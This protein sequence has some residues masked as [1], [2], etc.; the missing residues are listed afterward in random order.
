MRKARA[1]ARAVPPAVAAEV[2]DLPA[3][4]STKFV[5]DRNPVRQ[6]LHLG[7]SGK[8]ATLKD[9]GYSVEFA[10]DVSVR[11][12]KSTA[13]LRKNE[14][15]LIPKPVSVLDHAPKAADLAVVRWVGPQVRSKPSEVLDSLAGQFVFAEDDLKT[16]RNGLR[17]PQLGAIHAVLGYW[18]TNVFQPAT[19]VMPTGTGKT[20]AML[21]LFAV[22]RPRRILVVVPSDTLRDQVAV[23][24]ET[25]GVLRQ[26]GVIGASALRPVVGRVEH[27]FKTTAAARQFASECNVIIATASALTASAPGPRQ[28]LIDECSHL[29][30]DEAH[31]VAASTWK[32]IRDLF[33]KK[34]VLQFT[35]TPFREDGKPL[36]GRLLYSFP[37]K[38][39]QKQGYF[40]KINYYSV[41][42]FQN[43]DR[44]IAAKAVE[45]L[46][47]DLN[48]KR[49]HI[50]MARVKNISRTT[51]V[52]GIYSELAPDLNPV[53]LHSGLTQ[54]VRRE[55]FEAVKSRKSRVIVCVDMLGEGFDLP[56]LKVAAMH[57]THR[58]L[59]VTLQFIGRFA[60]PGEGIGEAT[61]VVGRPDTDHDENLRKLYAEDPDWNDIIQNLSQQAIGQEEEVSEF[62]KAFHELSD[63]VSISNLLPKMSTVVYRTKTEDWKPENITGLFPE[64]SLLTFP[65][66]INP[67]DHV[68]WFV[69]KLH[70]PVT[71]GDVRT[72]QDV[73]H[74]LY[75]VYWDATRQLLYVNS[76]NTDSLHEALAKTICGDDVER[77]IGENVFR[78]MHNV[79]RLVPTNV[80]VLDIH[81]RSRRF[82]FHV[83]ADV[84]EG[85]PLA[86]AKTKTKTNLFAYGFEEGARVSLGASLKG[87]VWS[88]QTAPSLKH[89]MDWCNH[90]GGKLIDDKINLDELMRKF[91]RPKVLDGRPA[92]IPLA[93]EWPWHVFLNISDEVKIGSDSGA[94]PLIDCELEITEFST[95]GPI[96]FQVTTPMEQ[97]PY[98]A[99]L[100]EGRVTYRATERELDLVVKQNRTPLSQWLGQQGLWIRFEQDAAVTPDGFWLKVDADLPPF[101]REQ[102][103]NLDWS[104]VD[105]RKESQGP[106]RAADSI[107]AR[108][109]KHVRGL[110]N[111][112][113]LI[114]D[115]G[116]GEVADVVALRVDG[117][118]L[119]VL[120][121][122]CK[123]SSG[124]K[125]GSRVADLYEVC[126][127]A[128]KSVKWEQ[129]A[130]VLMKHLIRR[131]QLRVTSGLR[132]GIEVG[133]A[134][135]FFTI[136]EKARMLRPR[137]TFAI[138][139]PGLSKA[140]ATT[141]QLQLLASAEVYVRET[142]NS[143]LTVFCSS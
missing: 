47:S 121:V 98:E 59:G 31:H 103:K 29:F 22:A 37:L 4:H 141:D 92:F 140:G 55:A 136:R 90:I 61:F 84:V 71:W 105:L 36:G 112:D 23:K 77:I 85:F 108:V 123:Y 116:T 109:I 102:L 133:K 120:L 49:D 27:G 142:A 46:R 45:Q 78:I 100:G 86:E 33:A 106:K 52:V 20:E 42:D 128:I 131:E 89:W 80:G 66:P 93:L 60:R 19:I 115:D 26:V 101:D 87:R 28:V 143:P 57:D 62:E 8:I 58:S 67:T 18:T 130:S 53:V 16:G 38:E 110:A 94:W 127:Q 13:K 3:S 14:R 75:V 65:V 124:D 91:I 97:V 17:I 129:D 63:D 24:F 69:T 135:T 30:V 12:L 126:G 74:D 118:D 111:W 1:P 113:L 35:A 34:H 64:E 41:V 7:G 83:G 134:S 79:N 10:H 21:G 32:Q 132:S 51:D 139:Q 114:D 82:S 44:T 96:K 48:Q 122:H 2:V 88:F 72:V 11:L 5:V 117:K 25:F 39:A 99:T 70:L 125:P 104:G 107:Q 56:A 73:K 54:K 43:P 95:T 9:G 76:S 40:S 6:V 50:V 15:A 68:A 81:N 138:A 119:E 137:F